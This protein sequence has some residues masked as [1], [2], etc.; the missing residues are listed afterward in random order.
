MNKENDM[1]PSLSYLDSP[2]AQPLVHFYP[3]KTKDGRYFAVSL[4]QDGHCAPS[5][6]KLFDSFG[7]LQREAGSE[8]PNR[9]WHPIQK[10]S[11]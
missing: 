5:V 6:S 11:F 2:S 4:I 9:K 10:D 7:A 3:Y 8:W 1:N